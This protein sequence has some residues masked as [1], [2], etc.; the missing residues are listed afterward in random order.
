MSFSVSISG[1]FGKIYS[2]TI[3]TNARLKNTIDCIKLKKK[4]SILCF[5]CV[6]YPELLVFYVEFVGSYSLKSFSKVYIAIVLKIT[7]CS[8]IHIPY[9]L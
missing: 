4:R 6:K 5:I 9:N 8:I 1:S 7:L 3:S 2:E